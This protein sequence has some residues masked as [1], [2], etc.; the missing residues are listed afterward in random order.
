MGI[1]ARDYCM[2]IEEPTKT[3]IEIPI[4]SPH[5]S[6]SIR[7]SAHHLHRLCAHNWVS[8]LIS[9]FFLFPFDRNC[10]GQEQERCKYFFVAFSTENSAITNT[11]K[12]CCVLVFSSSRFA[13]FYVEQSACA[14]NFCGFSDLNMLLYLC[15]SFC[16]EVDRISTSFP[17]HRRITRATRKTCYSKWDRKRIKPKCERREKK[18][19]KK[20]N[21]SYS[22]VF[23]DRNDTAESVS[24]APVGYC[25]ALSRHLQRTFL[26]THNHTYV[27]ARACG[28]SSVPSTQAYHRWPAHTM[29]SIHL[30]APPYICFYR[31][32]LN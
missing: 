16:Q 31:Q 15:L 23:G 4:K 8:L 30:H 32:P 9:F 11:T 28:A 14:S 20:N 21:I 13:D 12:E 24:S 25:C 18:G 29:P 2:Y 10:F 7:D 22:F 3:E 26:K 6:F 17:L 1:V 19:M 5:L 27:C